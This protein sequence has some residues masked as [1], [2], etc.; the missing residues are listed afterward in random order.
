MYGFLFRDLQSGSRASDGNF[1]RITPVDNPS[2]DIIAKSIQIVRLDGWD[3]GNTCVGKVFKARW[4]S[5]GHRGRRFR[6]HNSRDNYE[7]V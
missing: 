1:Q 3:P 2:P 6:R 7:C 4:W 5:R